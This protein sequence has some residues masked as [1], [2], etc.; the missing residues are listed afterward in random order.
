MTET[1][2]RRAADVQRKRRFMR[3]RIAMV[4]AGLA[5][6]LG[7]SAALQPANART[8]L[9]PPGSAVAGV[10]SDAGGF[11][12]PVSLAVNGTVTIVAS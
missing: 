12:D 10:I 4:V 11:P 1:F 2:R 7:S 5:L 6:L 9:C 3:R 8:V